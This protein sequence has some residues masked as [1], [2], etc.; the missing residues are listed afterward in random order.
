MPLNYIQPVFIA[1]HMMTTAFLIMRY[2]FKHIYLFHFKVYPST[3]EPRDI[4]QPV[5]EE[6]ET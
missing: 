6:H 3:E 5:Y 1:G 4:V 2:K